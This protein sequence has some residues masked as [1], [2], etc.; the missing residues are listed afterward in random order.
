M[1]DIITF[2]SAT[3]DVLLESEEF[4]KV[5]EEKRFLNHKGI[6]FSLGSKIP[7]SNITFLSGGGGTNTAFTFKNQGFKVV[8]CGCVGDD[9]A[10][11]DIKD[12]LKK[13]GISTDFLFFTNKKHTNYSVIILTET[14]RTAFVYKGASEE[15]KISQIPFQKIKKAKCFYLAP[16]SGKLAYLTERV[17]KFAKKEKILAVI[18]PGNTQLFLPKEKKKKIFS[19]ADILIL[20]QEEA[21]LASGLPP[22]KEKEIFKKIDNWVKGIFIM[23]KGPLGCIVS[24]GN[25]LYEAGVLPVKKVVDRTGCGDAFG[26]G[27]VTGY[28][29]W[30][31]KIKKTTGFDRIEYAIQFGCANSASCIEKLGAKQGLLSKGD[32]IFKRGK[33][34]IKKTKLK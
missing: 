6:C 24:D 17:L 12:E 29:R 32:N 14:E 28:L 10:G 1:Y 31:E 23:T 8:Y 7:I 5:R 34:K 16:F 21:S 33:V 18:N 26:S 22:Q 15:L 20:N 25:F 11:K 13:K 3:C 27:F 9:Y 4:G 30:N 2:G 19:L